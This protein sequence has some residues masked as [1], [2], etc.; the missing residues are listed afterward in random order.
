MTVAETEPAWLTTAK[1]KRQLQAEAIDPFRQTKSPENASYITSI[2]DV[3]QL[4][5]LIA[6]GRLRSEDV[7]LAYIARFDRLRR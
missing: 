3:G 1:K 7:T 6:E 2:D 5:S 4:A